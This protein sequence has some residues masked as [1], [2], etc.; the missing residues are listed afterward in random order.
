LKEHNLVKRQFLLFVS[1]IEPRKNIVRILDAY[2]S[3]P[4]AFRNRYPLVFTGSSG[5]KSEEV[6]KR[7]HRLS[8]TGLV[9]YLGYTSDAELKYLYSSAGALVFPS[10]YEGFGLPII[11]AQA[12][13]V[14]VVTSDLSC[15]PEVAG[16]A[17]LLVDPY[18]VQEISGALEQVMLDEDLRQKLKVSGLRNARQ[19]S[20]DKTA[21]K[22]L[23]VYS[24]L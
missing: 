4:Q 11:E 16:E 15:M 9:R 19:Y 17:A 5:W 24:R 14:P 6:L 8:D 13:G 2:E 20:W 12:M 1:S 3:L 18:N 22:T 7:I 23:D 21:V 10:I